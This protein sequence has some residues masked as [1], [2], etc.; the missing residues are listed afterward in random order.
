MAASSI[1]I[2]QDATAAQRRYLRG[3]CNRVRQQLGRTPWVTKHLFGRRDFSV[4]IGGNFPHQLREVLNRAAKVGVSQVF[5]R[6]GVTYAYVQL[7]L[8]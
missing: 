1:I 6:D 5:H 4:S 2:D 3:V 7:R 8:D